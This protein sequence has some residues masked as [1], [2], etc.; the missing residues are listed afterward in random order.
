MNEDK[1][2]VLVP[3]EYHLERIDMFLANSLELDFSRSYIQKL[4]KKSNILVNGEPTKPNYKVKEDD[5]IIID[6]PPPE[7][8]EVLPQD[9]P[10]NVVYQDKWLAVINKQPGL[11]V[12][13]GT[14]NWDRTL[15][16]ALMY[17]IKDLSGIGG[18]IRPGIV[19][20]LDKD[21]S[22]LMVIAKNDEAHEHLVNEFSNRNVKKKYSAIVVGKPK[23]EHDTISLPIKRHRKYRQK[24]TIDETG[25]EAVTEYRLEKIWNNKNGVYSMLHL[26]LHTGRTHQIRVHLSAIGNPIVGDSIYSKK[27]AKHRVPYFL[28]AS[29]ELDFA[30]PEDK[31]RV[32]FSIDLPGH[33]QDF[34]DKLEKS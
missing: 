10:V 13:P 25:R 5:V 9:M 11:V 34:I 26:D 30:H 6:I 20:R 2:E 29:M 18:V 33:M 21:T 14:G 17:H 28:L 23:K 12:H 27:W 19:H 32:S 16:N 7:Q 31:R 4:I 8:L 1:I 24:M 3:E 15:V 22:G